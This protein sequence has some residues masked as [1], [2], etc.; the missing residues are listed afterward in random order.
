[1][2]RTRVMQLTTTTHQPV[3]LGVWTAPGSTTATLTKPG[4]RSASDAWL[5]PGPLWFGPG[6][7][8]PW[9]GLPNRCAGQFEWRLC[10]WMQ[11]R[12]EMWPRCAPYRQIPGR[13]GWQ[14]LHGRLTGSQYPPA[15]LILHEMPGSTAALIPPATLILHATTRP[16]AA[17]IPPAMSLRPGW[18]NAAGWMHLKFGP[19]QW[20]RLGLPIALPIALRHLHD[21]LKESG[22]CQLRATA[23]ATMVS[24]MTPYSGVCLQS[25]PAVQRV[26]YRMALRSLVDPS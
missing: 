16:T 2:T 19:V 22:A 20:V 21:H 18:W 1:M 9:R 6:C 4:R 26:S 10:A 5:N 17:L 13:S 7:R 3:T 15:T 25:D 8:N 23:V 12:L 14:R 11:S 24:A